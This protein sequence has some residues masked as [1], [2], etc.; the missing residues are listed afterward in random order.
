VLIRSAVTTC[1]GVAPGDVC[2]VAVHGTGTP[3]GD[4]IEVGALAKALSDA[5]KALGPEAGGG[6]AFGSVKSVY[7]HTEGAAGIT[8]KNALSASSATTACEPA[9]SVTT[10]CCQWPCNPWARHEPMW[11]ERFSVGLQCRA[12]AACQASTL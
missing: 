7:G 10:S 5:Q 9:T 8:G 6:L 2:Y 3:L 1:N 12:K 11:P 4:P